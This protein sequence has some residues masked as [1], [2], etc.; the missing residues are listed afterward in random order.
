MR[1]LRSDSGRSLPLS[2]LK[3]MNG[4]VVAALHGGERPLHLVV[5]EDAVRQAGQRVIASQ[6]MDLGLGI[7]ALGHV[8][9]QHDRA[10]I[11]HRLEGERERAAVL[12]VDRELAVELAGEAAFEI[13]EQTLH[14]GGVERVGNDAGL[15]QLP[16]RGP[17]RHRRDV[18][19]LLDALVRHHQPPVRIEHAQA[20]RHVVERG[21]EPAGEQGHVARR[22]HGIEQGAAQAI[23]D[24]LQADE[25]RHQHAAEHREIEVAHQE[26]A[27]RH[28]NAGAE[29]CALTSRRLP[30]LRAATPIMF[31]STIAKARS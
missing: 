9:D 8:L 30:K 11:L 3:A 31:T 6:M 21:V 27:G 14:G 16:Q 12:G 24:R 25:E 26:Q 7:L 1:V 15:Q 17:A 10:A 28:R 5:E 4:A 23:R 20:M 22:D 18:Q 13:G 19:H 2:N 29:S